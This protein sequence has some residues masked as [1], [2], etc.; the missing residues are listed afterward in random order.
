[1]FHAFTHTCRL[2]KIIPHAHHC[3]VTHVK[4]TTTM[5]NN[6]YGYEKVF[7]RE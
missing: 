6:L 7:N 3:V 2:V 5:T 4:I 1:M